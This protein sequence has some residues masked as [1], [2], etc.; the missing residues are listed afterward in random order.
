MITSIK[1]IKARGGIVIAV[2]TEGDQEIAD[3]ADTVLPVPKTD[4]L[5]APVLHT[6]VLQL[7]SYYCARQ[8]GC[9]IDRPRNQ[10]KSVTVP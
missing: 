4:K 2:A 3:L 1:E 9:P 7:L 8:L 6:I 5:M 10:A